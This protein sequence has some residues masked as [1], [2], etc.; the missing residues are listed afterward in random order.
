M[1][2]RGKELDPVK[3]L[4]GTWENNLYKKG[5][6]GFRESGGEHSQYDN[7]LVT[8]IGF[9]PSAVRPDHDLLTAWGNIKKTY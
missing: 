8:T 4:V 3:H 6:I 5:A 7:V 9:E 2:E 1:A